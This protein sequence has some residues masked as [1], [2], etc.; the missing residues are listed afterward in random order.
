MRCQ[1][2]MAASEIDFRR[3]VAARDARR[4]DAIS[5]AGRF[6][7]ENNSRRAKDETRRSGMISDRVDP[8]IACS[9]IR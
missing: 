7:D 1:K 2:K 4:D 9:F 8:L 5:I 3:R 6:A